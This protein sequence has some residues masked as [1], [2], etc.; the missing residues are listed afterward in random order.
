ML[1]LDRWVIRMTPKNGGEASIHSY[2]T[3]REM[4]RWLRTLRANLF[5]SREYT[6]DTVDMG[7]WA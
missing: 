1:T 6:F 3:R 5:L 2:T 7:I 4:R